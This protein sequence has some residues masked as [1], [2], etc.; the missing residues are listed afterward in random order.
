MKKQ[1]VFLIAKQFFKKTFS[2]KGLFVLLFIYF[3]VLCYVTVDSWSA[4]E[5]QHH[6]IEHHQEESRKSWDN[7]PD[8]HP[9][10]MAHFGSFTFRIQHP[11]SIFD[12]GIE[13]YTGN[14]IFL[15]AHRQNTAN[16]S[17]A[18]LSTGLV[19]FGDLNIAMMLQLILPLIIFFIGYSA[20]TSEKEN[21]TLKIVHIQG[22]KIKE[23][24]FGKSLGLF[25][26]SVL[27]FIP[28]ILAL[29]SISFLEHDTINSAIIARC[30]LITIS[31]LLFYLILSCITVVVSGISKNSN[32]AL[33]SLLGVWLLFFIL[34]PKTA[35]VVG[36]S[37]HPNLSKIEFKAAVEAEVLKEGD[38]HNPDDPYFNGL[39][40]SVLKANNVTD[41]KDLP[42]NYSGFLMRKGEKQS[43][44]IYGNEHK[45]LIDTYRKQ[46]SITNG[47]VLVN[48][49]LAIKNLSMGFAG[50]DFDTYVNFL[51]QTENYRYEQAQYLNN[52][53][54][55]YISNKATSS[56]GKVHVVKKE[57]W[58]S[59][60]SFNYQYISIRKT[61]TKQLFAI[62]T[63]FVWLLLTLGFI[64]KFSNRF[65]II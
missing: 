17:E 16:F 51:T 43:A 49:Y 47:L 30:L 54:M 64:S 25:Y 50:T 9:H 41:I 40:D 8:K 37:I 3:A 31:Y 4:F 29:W 33:L 52:L 24:L 55:K 12:S 35:Q 63:L 38:S 20:I 26:V 48:P 39:R 59:L 53:Q 1:V 5:K 34:I 18:S 57:H 6:A 10:R 65:K 21:G 15:E 11:L 58:K 42:F 13:S 60:P 46:N 7:N 19:R 62:I 2:N 14:A 23:I 61:V 44:I 45:K 27:F 32:K 36:N 56:E 28:A 22:A